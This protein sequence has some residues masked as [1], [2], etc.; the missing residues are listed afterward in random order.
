M[1]GL[2]TP[3]D[4]RERRRRAR[5][6]GWQEEDEEEGE[7]QGD[8]PGTVGT[9]QPGEQGTSPLAMASVMVATTEL[10][11]LTVLARQGRERE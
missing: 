4:A 10:D 8:R 1:S 7:S 3:L 2:S 5:E 9:T 6:S 11:R